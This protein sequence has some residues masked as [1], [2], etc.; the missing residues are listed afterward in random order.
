M[1]IE[2]FSP[3]SIINLHQI[4]WLQFEQEFFSGGQTRD[5]W[6]LNFYVKFD[7][8]DQYQS[9][10]KSTGSFTMVFC[11]FCPDLVV[12][13]SIGGDLLEGITKNGANFDF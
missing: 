12:L 8:K 11:I 2:M 4:W 5:S 1:L 6:N 7:H 3:T 9:I 13:A 10:P